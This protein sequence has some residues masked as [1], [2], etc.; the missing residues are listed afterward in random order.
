MLD[1]F[2]SSESFKKIKKKKIF[3]VFIFI[4]FY[5]IF[6]PTFVYLSFFFVRWFGSLCVFTIPFVYICIYIYIRP[7]AVELFPIDLCV[8]VCAGRRGSCIH[9]SIVRMYKF[10]K[11]GWT[12]RH[13]S[14]YFIF[15]FVTLFFVF[16]VFLWSIPDQM[17]FLFYWLA[18]TLIHFSVIIIGSEWWWRVHPRRRGI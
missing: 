16:F 5:F 18:A 9:S 2:L 1:S 8:C 13:S 15:I 11:A 17:A 4:L 12:R 14:I 6:F 7:C 10:F 3:R